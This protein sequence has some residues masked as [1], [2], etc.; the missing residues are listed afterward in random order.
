MP[1]EFQ[2]FSW[3]VALLILGCAGGIVVLLGWL[4]LKSLGAVRQWTAI[5][6]RLLVVALLVLILGDARWDK[7]HDA[8]EVM[9][10]NDASA[11]VDLVSEFPGRGKDIGTVRQAL[12]RYYRALSQDDPTKERPDRIGMISFR[13]YAR[14]DAMP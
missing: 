14:V 10:L 5:G 3:P 2:N 7:K 4:S 11:S 9:I 13:H 8:L 1:L 6:I 12:D